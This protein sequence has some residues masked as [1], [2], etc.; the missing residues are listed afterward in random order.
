[1]TL[2]LRVAQ[3]VAI[4]GWTYNR[5]G[6]RLHVSGNQVRRWALG[7]AVPRP[8]KERIILDLSQEIAE[9]FTKKSGGS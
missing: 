3:I 4:T 9:L 2:N 7:L 1:M 6:I 5:I 8:D